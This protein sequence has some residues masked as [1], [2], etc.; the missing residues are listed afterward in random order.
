MVDQ[1]RQK[2]KTQID[3]QML[4]VSCMVSCKQYV[5]EIALAADLARQGGAT[6][7]AHQGRPVSILDCQ[8]VMVTI[9]M[10]LN[11]EGSEF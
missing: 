4:R 10:G 5:D 8:I 2:A 6:G 9:G 11:V 3:R 1:G 7:L